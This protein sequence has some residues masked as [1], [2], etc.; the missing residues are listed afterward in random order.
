MR[1]K[2]K[3]SAIL[4]KQNKPKQSKNK[5]TNKPLQ[6]NKT[7]TKNLWMDFYALRYYREH[8]MKFVFYA[9]RRIIIWQITTQ[10]VLLTHK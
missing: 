10:L 2:E 4:K 5:Q 9:Y 1:Q 8:L 3:N 7:K 6:Q